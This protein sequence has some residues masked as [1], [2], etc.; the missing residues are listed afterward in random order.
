M[1]ASA[2]CIGDYYRALRSCKKPLQTLEELSAELLAVIRETWLQGFDE[3][4]SDFGDT[5]QPWGRMFRAGRDDLT[6]PVGGGG[7][8]LLDLTTLRTMLYDEPNEHHK[9]HGVAR[10]TSTQVVVLSQPIQ[11]WIYLPVGLSDRPESAHYRDQAG[12]VF[13]ERTLRP[14]WVILSRGGSWGC[15]FEASYQRIVQ[16]PN[17]GRPKISRRLSEFSHLRVKGRWISAYS[18]TNVQVFF[19]F[20]TFCAGLLCLYSL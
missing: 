16:S 1:I 7:G 10:Q 2:R 18:A 9:R 14:S 11:S 4:R 3:M 20:L 13:W 6:W 17:A 19:V 8:A 5:A 15:G 12:T